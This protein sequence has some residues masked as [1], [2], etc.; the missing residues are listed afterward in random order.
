MEPHTLPFEDIHEVAARLAARRLSRSQLRIADREARRLCGALRARRAEVKS[1]L[2]R[3]AFINEVAKLVGDD[4]FGFHLAMETNTRELGIIHY[5]FSAAGTALDAV[6]NLIRYHRLVNTTTSFAVEETTRHV[7]INT[8]F[9]PGL[10]GLEKH[11]AE[12]GTTTFVAEIRRLTDFRIVP[13]SL[14]FIH[15][16]SSGIDE[17]RE[18]FGCPVRFGANRQ[19][20]AFAKHD[21]SVPIHSA[22]AH[23]LN[24][25]KVFCDEALSRRKEPATPTRVKV[26]AALIQMLSK[27]DATVTNVAGALAMSTRSLGRRLKEEA[28][29]YTAVL[30]ELRRDLAMQY[31]DDTTLDVSQI[32]WLLGYSEVSSFN[33]AFN[34]WTSSSPRAVRSSRKNRRGTT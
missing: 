24:I 32:A 18:F 3:I 21:L 17:F 9:R 10:E 7:S 11:V 1:Q 33:H 25:L 20:I 15:R 5:I 31:L 19:S 14:T 12:W 8:T 26:E 30:D 29:S 2:Q 28:T 22:D 27:G 16:R 34:R 4:C 23:L 13:Q 6:K